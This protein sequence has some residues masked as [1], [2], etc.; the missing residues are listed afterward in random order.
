MPMMKSCISIWIAL[1][2]ILTMPVYTDGD[3]ESNKKVELNQEVKSSESY[4]LR[5][6][7]QTGKALSIISDATMTMK[8]QIAGMAMPANMFIHLTLSLKTKEVLENGDAKITL[9][10]LS[11]EGEVDVLGQKQKMP[12]QAIPDN[13]STAI[14]VS[15][16][17]Q[18]LEGDPGSSLMVSTMGPNVSA[19]ITG[20]FV[21]L[22]ENPVVVGE[23]WKSENEIEIPGSAQKMKETMQSTLEKVMEVNGGKVAVIRSIVERTGKDI[24][25]DAESMAKMGSSLPA[26]ADNITISESL[27]KRDTLLHFSLDQGHV[28]W[29]QEKNE[30]VTVMGGIMGTGQIIRTEINSENIMSVNQ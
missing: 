14:T 12:A 26:M 18:L 16:R 22:P 2:S 29:V 7:F 1:F 8:N 10:P 3:T 30:M 27:Q 23:S 21:A 17:G 9:E 11:Y 13:Q 6:S 15:N 28:L 4:A 20:F 25:L 24:Q 19:I 5:Y